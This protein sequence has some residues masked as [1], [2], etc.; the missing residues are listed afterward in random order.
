MSRK[1]VNGMIL[2]CHEQARGTLHTK[3]SM[4]DG[5]SGDVLWVGRLDTKQS[6]CDGLSRDVLWVRRLAN[7]LRR[8]VTPFKA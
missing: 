7:K 4:C 8:G 1:L 5:L 3:Q 2:Y 6:M